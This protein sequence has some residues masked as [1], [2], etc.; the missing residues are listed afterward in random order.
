MATAGFV[1]GAIATLWP[2]CVVLLLV[3]PLPQ[4]FGQGSP[5]K[6]GEITINTVE[7]DGRYQSQDYYMHTNQTRAF[8]QAWRRERWR[9]GCRRRRLLLMLCCCCWPHC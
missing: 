3:H 7:A 5:A 2:D 4:P 9:R 8:Q 6:G 1:R